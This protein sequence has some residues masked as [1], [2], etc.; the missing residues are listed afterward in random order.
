MEKSQT[1]RNHP[2]EK[3]GERVYKFFKLLES[4]LTLS[5][6]ELIR[7][8]RPESCKAYFDV[9]YPILIPYKSQEEAFINGH[10]R[11]YKDI[12]SFNGKPYL[13]VNDWYKR[14]QEDFNN[15]QR[16]I[17]PIA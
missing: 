7:L 17:I 1:V 8:Q 6:N 9:N 14:N 4:H 12:F 3:I 13:L 2:V 11:Y 10:R 5:E 15:W 16:K